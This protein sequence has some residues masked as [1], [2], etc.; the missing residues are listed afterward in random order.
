[1][2]KGLKSSATLSIEINGEVYEETASGDGQ[3]DAFMNAL[4]KIYLKLKKKILSLPITTSPSHPA[5][6]QMLLL[7]P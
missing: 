3:Y 5:G 4:K 6:K 1:V 2:A 7:K